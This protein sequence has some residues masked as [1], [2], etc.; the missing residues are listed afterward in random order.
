MIPSNFIRKSAHRLTQCAACNT[1]PRNNKHLLTEAW[2]RCIN[3]E[4]EMHSRANSGLNG[5][6]ERLF[7]LLSNYKHKADVTQTRTDL[8]QTVLWAGKRTAELLPPTQ[9]SSLEHGGDGLP[10]AGWT[11]MKR[12][13]SHDFTWLFYYRHIAIFKIEN[14]LLLQITLIVCFKFS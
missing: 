10:T 4:V 12:E 6:S 9:T 2:S 11:D 8:L 13:L 5:A 14:D 7:G 1:L 3:R